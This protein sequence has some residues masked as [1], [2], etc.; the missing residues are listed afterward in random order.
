MDNLKMT[1][2]FSR[3]LQ[4]EPHGGNK[5][6]SI[7]FSAYID[8]PY[9]GVN[10]AHDVYKLVKPELNKLYEQMREDA[11]AKIKAESAVTV[12]PAEPASAPRS[13]FRRSS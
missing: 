2:G 9:D 5:F 8:I 11:I 7:D 3:K 12:K 6:E 13:P 10:S 1:F 4:A